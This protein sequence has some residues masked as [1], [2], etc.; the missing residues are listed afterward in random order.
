MTRNEQ[1]KKEQTI[2]SATKLVEK[3]S[4]NCCV[5]DE[6][7][8]LRVLGALIGCQDRD[9]RENNNDDDD[10]KTISAVFASVECQ[11]GAQTMPKKV[12]AA[13]TCTY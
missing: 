11:G 9:K 12:N 2:Y 10:E 1:E 7:V 5:I 3:R 6:K 4:G 13:I 8:S